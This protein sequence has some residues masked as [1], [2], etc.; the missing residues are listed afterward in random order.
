M[1]NLPPQMAEILNRTF[2]ASCTDGTVRATAG[3]D[4]HLHAVEVDLFDDRDP[5]RLG[6]KLTEACAA[7]L[8]QA[9]ETTVAAIDSSPL[10]QSI[11]GY[12]RGQTSDQSG[13][14]GPYEA[15]SAPVSAVVAGDG[16]LT[17]VRVDRV[18]EPEQVAQATLTC[19]NA[20]LDQALGADDGS[21]LD[22]RIAGRMADLDAALERLDA[23][24]GPLSNRLDALTRELS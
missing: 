18:T 2:T 14:G 19:V 12:L 23:A 10:G 7:A 1:S 8:L 4:L 11:A 16:S 24:V 9:R 15:S 13:P 20:A 6:K 5:V 22:V 17:S 3:A 21:D